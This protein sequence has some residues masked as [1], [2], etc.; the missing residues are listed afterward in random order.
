MSTTFPWAGFGTIRFKRHE[1][2][3]IGTDTGWNANPKF[4]ESTPTGAIRN[5]IVTL[6]IG[7][8]TRSF[9]QYMD[10]DRVTAYK[11]LINTSHVLT[12]FDRPSPVQRQAF[13]RNVR[14]VEHEVVGARRRCGT[15][16]MRLVRVIADFTSQ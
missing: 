11:A 10:P 15:T 1:A 3:I 2:P 4:A 6:S 9:E 8:E 13:L 12:D 7:S 16:H 5:D 14:E